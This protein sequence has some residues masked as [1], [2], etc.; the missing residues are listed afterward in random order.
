[1][2][3]LSASFFWISLVLLTFADKPDL[4]NTRKERNL[5]PMQI[6]HANLGGLYYLCAEFS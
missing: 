4:M 6:M 3:I 1:M 2:S 5:S